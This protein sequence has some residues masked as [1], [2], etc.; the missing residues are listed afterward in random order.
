MKISPRIT[1]KHYTDSNDIYRFTLAD[2]HVSLANALRR[3][4]LSEIETIIFYTE[5]YQDNKC[6]VH[7]NTCRLH[8]EIIKQRLS[9][10]PIWSEDRELVDKYIM[11]VQVKNETDSMIHVT[12]EHFR[13]K[14]KETGNYLKEEA[15]RSIF[16][17]NPITGDFI[18]FV[19]LRPA[20]G[21]IIEGEEIHLSCEF[22]VS[23]AKVNSMFN[24]VS[25]CTYGNT[26][27]KDKV[28][29]TLQSLKQKWSQEAMTA[30]EIEF[31]TKNFMLLDAERQFIAN[32]YDFAV[33][34]VGPI[35][36][37]KIVKKAC[38]ILQNK[39]VDFSEELKSDQIQILHSETTIDHC[40]DVTLENEDYTV[41]K[42][43]EYILYEKYFMEENLMSFCGFKKIHP[44][45]N[46][47]ILRIAYK[48]N[49]DK[50]ML[51]E[52]LNVAA[53]TAAGVFQYLGTIM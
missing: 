30:D 48:D 17:P 16:P 37:E 5:T 4:I 10:I 23:M 36:N 24:V 20:I 15:V 11:E 46:D 34:T 1:N 6:T 43:L 12:T 45:N 22:S 40:Y 28:E 21:D 33:K 53:I 51:R 47:S 3:I 8:N 13:I 38:Q 42:V 50:A 2:I 44:H 29:S 25:K 9:C 35:S 31:Q 49:L 26:V 39:F 52:H 7:K 19:R 27:D 32:S 14:N 18:D 41:G